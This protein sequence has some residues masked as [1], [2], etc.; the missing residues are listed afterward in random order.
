MSALHVLFKV[1]DSDYALPASEVLHME[2]FERATRVPGAPPYVAGVIQSRR[3]VVPVVD[4]RARFGLPEA[5]RTLDARVIVVQGCPRIVGLLVD[6]AREV[7]NIAPEQH[8]APPEVVARDA[9]GFVRSIAQLGPRLI[10]LL[11]AQ[12]VIGEEQ[13][14]GGD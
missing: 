2:S 13:L 4:L 14:Q 8:H 11:D 12:K 9:R 7:L 5:A 6:S 3:R 10:M 1:A